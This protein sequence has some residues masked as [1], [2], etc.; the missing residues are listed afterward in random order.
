MTNHEEVRVSKLSISARS[1]IAVLALSA[2]LVAAFSLGAA[3]QNAGDGESGT[4]PDKVTV[5]EEVEL[6]PGPEAG[7]TA[8]LYKRYSANV[9][10]PYDDDMNYAY[11]AGGCVSRI[12]GT[13]MSEHTVQLPD[14]AE[15]TYLRVYFYDMDADDDAMATLYS[16]DGAG[17]YTLIADAASSGTPG[18]SSAGSGPFSYLVDNTNEA[19]ALRLDFNGGT[20]S[21]L[22]ICGVRLQYVY[23][24]SRASLPEILSNANP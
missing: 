6:L 8:T 19:L 23:S 13:S 15:I 17:N 14:D 4:L 16:F 7:T 18:Q 21:T 5:V 22:R 24:Y 11:Q 20:N 10:V 12:S 3:A 2:L 9:F 1:L